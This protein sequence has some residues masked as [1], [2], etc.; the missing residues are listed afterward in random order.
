MLGN[1]KNIVKELKCLNLMMIIFYFIDHYFF[2]RAEV[3][4]LSDDTLDS[5]SRVFWLTV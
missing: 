5:A 1:N 2:L 3:D 4:K